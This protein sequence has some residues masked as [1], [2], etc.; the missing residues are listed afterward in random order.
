MST[1]QMKPLITLKSV[2]DKNFTTKK[3]L[4]RIYFCTVRIVL[5]AGLIP[6][7]IT[8]FTLCFSLCQRVSNPFVF[9]IYFLLHLLGQPTTH[10]F[11]VLLKGTVGKQNILF[12]S[13]FAILGCR[14]NWNYERNGCVSLFSVGKVYTTLRLAVIGRW[15][16][17]PLYFVQWTF[18]ALHYSDYK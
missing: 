10:A 14:E 4:F 5:K 1:Q 15:F 3:Q 6:V 12:S 17:R 11:S 2:V 18:K 9:I 13:K 8:H 7:K 16:K